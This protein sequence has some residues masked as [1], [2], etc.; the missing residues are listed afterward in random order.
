MQHTKLLCSLIIISGWYVVFLYIIIDLS[1]EPETNLQTFKAYKQI[2]TY[3]N[4]KYIKRE[5]EKEGE[6]KY[7]YIV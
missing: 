6:R 5:K 2:S 1:E 4:N 7:H 3:L